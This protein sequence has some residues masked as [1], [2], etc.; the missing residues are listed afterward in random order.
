MQAIRVH[1]FGG[2]EVLQ[3]EALG[4]P[5]PSKGQVL[6][7]VAAAGVN[8]V[9]TY[10]RSGNYPTLPA[11]PWTPGSDAGGIVEAIGEG[12]TQVAVGDAVYTCRT[13]TGTYATHTLAEASLVRKLPPGVE[14]EVG[15]CVFVPYYTAF[16]AAFHRGNVLPG[17]RVL[18]HGSTGG[19][20]LAALQLLRHSG[21]EVVATAGSEPGLQL[22]KSQGAHHIANHRSSGYLDE[23]RQRFPGGFDVILEM[24]ANVNLAADLTLLAPFGR[25]VVIGNRG[26]VTINPRLT[27]GKD[28]DIRGMQLFNATPQ[29]MDRMHAAIY[30]GFATGSLKPVIAHRLPLS[31]VA[32]AHELIY[33]PGSMGKIVLIP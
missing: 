32:R 20:G 15:A 33:R 4:T 5:V 16:Q 9:E 27:M 2:P 8:P 1:Q 26:E 19:V 22:L 17:D 30:R 13:L 14:P 25:V 28:A 23:L 24:L 7:R 3:L 21:A 6:L 18:I 31:E 12:V 10:I 11:L 29:Q